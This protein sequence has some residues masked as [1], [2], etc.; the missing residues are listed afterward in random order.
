MGS[1]LLARWLQP[2]GSWSKLLVAH[3]AGG[4]YELLSEVFFSVIGTTP[5]RGFLHS[6]IFRLP[7]RLG[8]TIDLA[9]FVSQ[10]QCGR[11]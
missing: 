1:S 9:P 2:L 10:R 7:E 5:W 6:G 8:L 11:N 4:A 3:S